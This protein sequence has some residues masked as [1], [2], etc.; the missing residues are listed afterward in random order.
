MQKVQR[1]SQPFCTSTKARALGEAGRQM[2]GGLAHRHDVPTSDPAPPAAAKLFRF[3][4]LGIAEHPVDFRHRGERAGIDLGGAAGD[5]DA[6]LGPRSRRLA[7]R[8]AGLAHRF[9]G[10]RAGVDDDQIVRPPQRPHRLDLSGVEPAP[11][12]DDRAV[13]SLAARRMQEEGVGRA[14]HP[15]RPPG[16]PFDGQSAPPAARHLDR[17]RRG[18]QPAPDRGDARRA[19]AGAAGQG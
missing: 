17:A 9:V 10:H 11:E 12:G 4:L 2:R 8:L 3:E 6:R 5:D 7:D 13:R 16:C 1:W 18:R 14:A 19:G 15:D